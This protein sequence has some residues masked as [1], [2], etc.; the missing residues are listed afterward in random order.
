M[1]QK[2]ELQS[3]PFLQIRAKEKGTTVELR[4]LPYDNNF[5]EIPN[6][7]VHVSFLPF[8]RGSRQTV[9]SRLI[10]PV[11]SLFHVQTKGFI[12]HLDKTGRREGHFRVLKT[13]T[14]KTRLSLRTAD[15]FP[16]VAV[17]SLPPLFFGGR[18]ATTGNA[19]AVQSKAKRG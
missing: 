3:Y 15:A 1:H 10:S 18:E 8:G 17:A 9:Y 7:E 4:C 5:L 11:S 2:G 12:R 6:L 14:F 16:V 19:S 13:L